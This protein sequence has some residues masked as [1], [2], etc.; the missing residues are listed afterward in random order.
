MHPASLIWLFAEKYL[1]CNKCK[2]TIQK[3]NTSFEYSHK[4]DDA[5]KGGLR[6]AIG[7]GQSSETLMGTLPLSDKA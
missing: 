5:E 1:G 3:S 4:N 2:F 6:T 7:V